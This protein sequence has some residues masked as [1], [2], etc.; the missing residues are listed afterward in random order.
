MTSIIDQFQELFNQTTLA[1]IVQSVLPHSEHPL[2]VLQRVKQLGQPIEMEHFD[3]RTVVLG[4]FTDGSVYL[5]VI[6]EE[7]EQ[8]AW[9]T[10]AFGSPNAFRN[11]LH[12]PHEAGT[13]KD[14][15]VFNEIPVGL[16]NRLIDITQEQLPQ[17][18]VP[19]EVGH[20]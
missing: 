12:E 16:R 17:P 20:A 1:E 7:P 9:H 15:R 10:G 8:W 13:T 14:D 6:V 5:A 2:R 3:D 4:L 18:T 11:W 19:G